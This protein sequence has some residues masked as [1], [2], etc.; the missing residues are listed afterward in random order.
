MSPATRF[1][2]ATF[3][4]IAACSDQTGPAATQTVDPSAFAAVQGDGRITVMT[5]NLYLGA[6]ADQVIGALVSADP[7]DDLPALQAAIATLQGTDFASRARAI[8]EQIERFRPHAVGLQEAY[9]IHVDLTALGL[10]VRI[11]LDYLRILQAALSAR[12][13]SYIVAAKVLDTD[14]QPF[15]G[16][17]LVDWD[18]LLVDQSR[19]RVGRDRDIIARTF[20]YN[21]GPLAPGIDKRAGY[22]IVP[23]TV[24]GAPVTFVTTH[25]ESDLGPDSHPQI[26]QLR[27]AQAAEIV[28]VL[29]SVSPVILTGD[30]NDEAGSP[31]YQVLQGAGFVD[32]WATLRPRDPGLTC[33]HAADLSDAVPTFDQRIDFILARG[34]SGGRDALR[35]AV[36]LLGSHRVRGPLGPTWPSDHA[37]VV[38]LFAMPR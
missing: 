7:T 15:P 36:D 28:G 5:Q 22:I 6:D 16:I 1:A 38:A 35:G 8:A 18:V 20:Q 21:I 9:Q 25:L 24:D 31:M 37:G 23:A 34:M 19:V 12:H 14:A 26:A 27:A 13:L 33:C 2:I 3:V 29:G 10:P 17:R 32:A 11:D 4:L 30:L